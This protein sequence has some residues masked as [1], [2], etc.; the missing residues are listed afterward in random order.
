MCMAAILDFAICSKMLK[1]ENST[2][3]Q[4]LL[5]GPQPIII[6]RE[7]NFNSRNEVHPHGCQTI[8][9]KQIYLQLSKL[10]VCLS[11]D[12][13]NGGS[14]VHERAMAVHCPAQFMTLTPVRQT[15]AGK[16]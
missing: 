3:T 14:A 2:P 11:H 9:Y 7:K 15:D 16:K 8:S 4:I 5:Y 12:L 1:G 13:E 6:S 10:I